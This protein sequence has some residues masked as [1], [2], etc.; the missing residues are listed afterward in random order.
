M[1]AEMKSRRKHKYGK[2]EKKV[3]A[4]PKAHKVAE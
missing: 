4:A 2:E 3:C 1:Y